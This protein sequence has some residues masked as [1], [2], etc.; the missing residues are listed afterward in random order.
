MVLRHNI[1]SKK[2]EHNKQ[3]NIKFCEEIDHIWVIK[4]E[5][6]SCHGNNLIADIVKVLCVVAR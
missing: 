4:V 1:D 5:G 6:G 3:I 2:R